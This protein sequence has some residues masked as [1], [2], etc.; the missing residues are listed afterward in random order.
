[1]ITANNA[2]LLATKILLPRCGPSLIDRP[3]LVGQLE[4]VQAKQ[5]SLIRAG[6]G[7]G[8]TTLAVAWAEQLQQAGKLVAW[9]ALDDEDDE[10]YRFLFYVSHALRRATDTV[11]ETAIDLI[12][13]TS[14]VSLKA[15]VSSW[16]ND[17]VEL[18]EDF[19]LFLDDY[20]HITDPEI[21]IGVSYLLRYAPTQFHLIVTANGDP[22]LPLERLRSRRHLVEIDSEALR[23]DVEETYRLL[24]QENIDGLDAPGVR[25]LQAKTEGW[26]AVLRIVAATFAQS[27]QNFAGYAERLSGAQRPIGGY[28]SELLDSLPYD[29]VQF[30]LRIAILDRLSAPLCHAVTGSPSSL[31]FLKSMAARQILLTPLDNEG[32]WYRFHSLLAGHLRHRLETELGNEARKLHRRA[33]RWFA[34]QELWTEAVQHAIAAGDAGSAISW[35]ENCAMALVKKG[36][37]LTLLGWQ[38]LFPADLARSRTS[39]LAIAWALTL[40]MRFDDALELL[41]QVEQEAGDHEGA[42]LARLGCELDTIRCLVTALQDDSLRALPMAEAGMNRATEPWTVNFSANIALFAY[43]KAGDLRRFYAV[44][45]ISRRGDEDRRIV[46][47]AVYRRCLHG[48]VAFERL[49]IAEAERCYLEAM[50]LA[51]RDAGPNTAAAALPASLLSRI[52]YEQ[53]RFDEAEAIVIDRS[54]MI[55]ATGML[56][57]VLSA[58]L[59]LIEVA[60]RRRNLER[61]HA[62]LEQLETLGQARKWGRIVAAA[63]ATKLRL[64]LAEGRITRAGACLN[65]LERLAADHPAPTRCA[66]SEIHDQVLLA[67]GLMDAAQNRLADAI[68][69]L[70]ALRQQAT[71]AKNDYFAVRVACH[72]AVALLAADEAGEADQVFAEIVAIAAPAGLCMTIIGESFETGA[73]LLRFQENARRSGMSGELPAY[74][75]GLI[76]AWRGLHHLE[77]KAP[78]D[79]QIVE[80]LSPRERNILD[81]VSQ[82]RSNKEIARQLGIAPETVKSHI[83]NI[84]IKLSVERR[85]Q[86]VSRAYSLGLVGT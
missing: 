1:M 83:K 64:H 20:H 5:V 71:N 39:V 54:A 41:S 16:I 74:V 58:H 85:A 36:D 62:L 4:Q 77:G 79:A 59:V 72:L 65:R 10:P 18:D 67:R 57:S 37:L 14:P 22:V 66:W 34:A 84:F 68:A 80:S 35:I 12:S 19:Y 49:Q 2:Q 26:P 24:R 50:D 32:R 61:A 7:F 25:H 38:R 70:R 17:L 45:W 29:L 15:V 44:P 33:S 9:V 3:R 6:P 75:G 69:T 53:G 78:P 52:R 21:G 81:R 48:L 28:L 27:G 56:D 55:D 46:F 40:T 13:D 82:G 73:L 51:D 60:A 30:M 76:T 43:W 8:K 63:L 86:A 31:H 47:A 11:G 42:E 23:F